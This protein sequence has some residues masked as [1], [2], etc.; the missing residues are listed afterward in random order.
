MLVD[1][2]TYYLQQLY[3]Y[4]HRTANFPCCTYSLLSKTL[5]RRS[6]F[7]GDL[8]HF[9]HLP[10]LLSH[11]IVIYTRAGTTLSRFYQAFV[12]SSLCP[13]R[14]DVGC[15]WFYLV[16]WR[17]YLDCFRGKGKMV[18]SSDYNVRRKFMDFIYFY[19]FFRNCTLINCFMEGFYL[20][21]TKNCFFSKMVMLYI[22]ILKILYRF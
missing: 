13:F 20:I 6:F 1:Q 7:W 15:C 19:S 4:H 17:V 5:L 10:V 3:Q 18:I 16:P 9:P 12:G 21:F 2:T 8:V 11:L 22:I 14:S